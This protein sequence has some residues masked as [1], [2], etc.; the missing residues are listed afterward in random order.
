LSSLRSSIALT[1][2]AVAFVFASNHA[3][4]VGVAAGTSIDNTAQV[5][6]TVGTTSTT[7]TSNTVSVTVAEI[8]DVVVTRQSAANISVTAGATQQE[9][10][11]RVTNT[12][13]GPETFRLVMNSVIGGDDFD[14]APAT[15]S[16]YFDTDASGDLS[17]GDTPYSVGANDPVLN[18]DA[19]VTVL[20]VN[21]IPAVLA[22]GTFG[23]SELT[24]DARTGTG[25][26]GTTYAG[27]GFNGTD[28]VVGT[29]GALSVANGHY[30]VAGLAVTAV[31]SQ[32]VVDQ[33]GGARPVP[34]ARI[35][36]TIVVNATGSGSAA[37]S[38]FTDNIPANT[39]YVPG[40]LR[41]NSAVLSDAADAD[42]GDFVAA[43]AARVLVQLGNITQ[44][45]GSQTIQ[46]AVT[47]N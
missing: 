37:N 21:D 30:L 47:I 39:T 23:I 41:L 18:A 3:Q 16:I 13:N 1:A 11:F 28:A 43:P 9:I 40:T 44:A 7:A 45:S 22:D 8:L 25:A 31:K 36:Y 20:V 35:N 38:V 2:F 32:S 27:Q 10:V 46:F 15:P 19:F 5:T 29:T 14:P 12:G 26:P 34:G 24:A 6:Y 4:A 33:F 42:A 17:P